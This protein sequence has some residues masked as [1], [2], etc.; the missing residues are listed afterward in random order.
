MTTTTTITTF[1]KL[2]VRKITD[3]CG[4]ALEAIAVKYG[5]KLDRKNCSYMVDEMPVAYRLLTVTPD[6]NGNAL[7]ADGKEFRKYA[8]M[9]GLKPADLGREFTSR[10]EK[11]RICGLKSRSPKFPVL[12]ENIRTGKVYKFAA[13]GVLRAL[14]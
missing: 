9:F 13:E 6:E 10:G 8:A 3:E 14:T 11:F 1:D 5:L 2:T 7:D 4:K 12:A